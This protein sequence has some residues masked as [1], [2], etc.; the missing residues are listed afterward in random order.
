MTDVTA[1]VAQAA[2]V[3]LYGYPLVYNLDEIAKF[4]G[5]PSVLGGVP[6]P[7]N[8]LTGAPALLGPDATFVSPNNDTLYLMAAMNLGGGPLL[9]RVPDTGGRYYVLQFV[10]AWTNNFAYIGRRATGTE[11]GEFVLTPP[12]YEGPLPEGVPVVHFPTRVGVIVGRIAVDG[13]DD[14]PAVH[15]LQEQFTLTTL[16]GGPV[17]TTPRLPQ[18]D[19]RV[20][21]ELAWWESFRVALAAFPP[22]SA[23]AE[24]LAGCAQLGLTA[25]ESPYVDADP[26][27][28]ALLVDAQRAGEAELE[29]LI[30]HAGKPVNGW[31]MTGHIFDYNDDFFEVGTL[32]TAEWTI[33]DRARAY[34][35]RAVA[36]RAGLWGNHGYEAT[37]LVVY[38]DADGQPLDSSHR[39]ELT[40]PAAPPVEAFWSLTMYDVPEFYLVGNEIDRY[41]VGDR[42]PGLVTAEDGSF[43]LYLQADRP[44][45]PEKAAN[46]LPTPKQGP[47]RP[48]MRLYQPS[49]PILDGT[50]VLPPIRRV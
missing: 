11:A 49:A 4:P 33:P 18:P 7:F 22:P 44:E 50:F 16:D 13:V 30:T 25:P 28:A 20:P 38:V 47:F 21:A 26:Q 42:T 19:P 40:L 5:G 14:V 15:A 45:E 10:D 36:A 39:Y 17:D 34:A 12:G 37:Y 35:T 43:T 46:W 2:K 48:I 32:N 31:Q 6:A 8:T 9:L 3:F 29:Q 1:Q 41:A 24:F 23:D 27:L